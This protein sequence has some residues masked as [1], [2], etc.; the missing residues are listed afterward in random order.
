MGSGSK[1]LSEIL[2]IEFGGKGSITTEATG[3]KACVHDL[4]DCHEAMAATTLQ[5]FLNG[6]RLLICRSLLPK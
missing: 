2:P 5:S 1:S 4:S 6:P 3:P